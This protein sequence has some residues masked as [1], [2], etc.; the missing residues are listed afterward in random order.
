MPYLAGRAWRIRWAVER[1][2]V[3]LREAVVPGAEPRDVVTMGGDGRLEV[4]RVAQ[5]RPAAVVPPAP[6]VDQRCDDGERLLVV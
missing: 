1:G 6:K 3:V 4:V 2:Q 5:E